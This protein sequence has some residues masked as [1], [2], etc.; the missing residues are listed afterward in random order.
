M[1][2]INNNHVNV[3]TF[4]SSLLG[5]HQCQDKKGQLPSYSYIEL[6]SHKGDGCR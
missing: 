2:Y 5:N 1:Y 4:L 3:A 6:Y